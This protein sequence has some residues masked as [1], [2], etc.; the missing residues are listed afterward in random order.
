[1]AGNG[2][3]RLTLSRQ[4]ATLVLLDNGA[5]VR[6]QPLAA[7]TGVYITGANNEADVLTVDNAGGPVVVPGGIRFD[8][9]SG[10]GNNLFL[11]G[12]PAA[13]ALVLTP[14][15]GILNGAEVVAFANVAAVSAFGSANDAAFLFDNPVGADL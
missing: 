6:S 11:T 12:T 1:P 15:Y 8:G 5:V 10:G 2:T 13:D 7:T 3:D 4:G 14:A 9:G